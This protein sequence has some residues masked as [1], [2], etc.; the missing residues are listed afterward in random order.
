MDRL[1]R[2]GAVADV[3]S[4]VFLLSR[5]RRLERLNIPCYVRATCNPDGPGARWIAERF[6]IQPDGASTRRD[7]II[8]GRR[9][10]LRF[11]AARLH[12]ERGETPCG[13]S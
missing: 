1:G 3:V 4:I 6:D 2:T 13:K 5:L 9:F 7:I 10:R 8:E 11:I 12:D